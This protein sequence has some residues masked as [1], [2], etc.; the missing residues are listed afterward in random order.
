[1]RHKI[2]CLLVSLLMSGF[3]IYPAFAASSFPDVDEY[4]EYAEAVAYVSEAGIMVGDDQGNFNP[5]SSVSRAE[6]ATL[7][8]RMLGE[9]EGLQTSSDFSDVPTNHWANSYVGKAAELG[10][11][12]GY[13]NGKFGPSDGV[14]Y[15]QAVTMI[16]RALDYEDEAIDAGGYPNGYLTI[17]Q[18]IGL[19]NGIR[20][21]KETPLDRGSVAI[22]IYNCYH[23]YV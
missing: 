3:L 11:V 19:L 6:M 7:I 2:Q 14:T 22:I 21:K 13:G 17:A 20:A 5:N 1:M 10:I 8:C 15:E 12:N 4:S 16:V 18:N 9:T 23:S